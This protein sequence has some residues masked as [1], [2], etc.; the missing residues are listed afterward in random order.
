[1]SH[2]VV[3]LERH[4]SQPKE[5]ARHRK[6]RICYRPLE[7]PLPNLFPQGFMYFYLRSTVVSN[8]W[9]EMVLWS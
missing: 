2:I 9:G 1:M 6:P 8:L 4:P 5:I 7:T 3:V